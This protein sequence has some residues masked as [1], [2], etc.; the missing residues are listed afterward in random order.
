TGGATL[1]RDINVEAE[2]QLDDVA[3]VGFVVDVQ[4][5]KRSHATSLSSSAA[6]S[7]TAKRLRRVA[8]RLS[9]EARDRINPSWI[10]EANNVFVPR[11]ENTMTGMASP[12]LLRSSSRSS[13]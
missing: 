1:Y 5:P 7:P 13:R 2:R 10:R 3:D 11:A 6:E 8:T 4:D 12:S 9:I